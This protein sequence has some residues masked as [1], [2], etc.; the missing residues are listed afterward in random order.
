MEMSRPGTP[1]LVRVK[2]WFCQITR[3]FSSNLGHVGSDPQAERGKGEVNLSPTKGLTL[4]PR[5][6]GFY[7]SGRLWE[8]H[9]VV[10]Y[11]VLRLLGGPGSNDAVVVGGSAKEGSHVCGGSELGSYELRSELEVELGS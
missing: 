10:F 1:P 5:V 6:G 7:V 3:V 9:S 4:R 2:R 8:V 11:E